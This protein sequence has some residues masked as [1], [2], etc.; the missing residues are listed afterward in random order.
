MKTQKRS[1]SLFA[2]NLSLLATHQVDAAYHHE[3]E[4]FRVP[5][6][7]DFFLIFNLV[8]VFLLALGYA[9]VCGRTRHARTAVFGSVGVGLFTFSVHA[10]FLALGHPAFRS[11]LSLGILI[12]ILGT[13]IAQALTASKQPS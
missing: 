10:L 11:P 6:G 5:G 9:Q 3:W 1:V 8:A 4:M 13:S 7:I 2:L 12:A